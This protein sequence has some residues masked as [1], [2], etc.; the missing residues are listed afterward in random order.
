[1]ISDTTTTGGVFRNRGGIDLTNNK[2]INVSR[3]TLPQDAANKAYVDQTIATGGV[4]TGWSGFT[5]NNTVIRSRISTINL[6]NNGSGYTTE[7]AVIIVSDSGTGAVARSVL[8]AGSGP[9]GVGSIV[10]DD[11]GNGYINAPTVIIG[12]SIKDVL[13]SFGGQGYSSTPTLTFSEPQTLGGVRATGFAVM[14]GVGVNQRIERVVITNAGAGYTNSPTITQTHAG[15]NPTIA[16]NLVVNLQEGSGAIATAIITAIPRNINLNGNK[17]TG[18]TD[19]TDPTD[20]VTLK[21]FDESNFVGLINDVTITG[22]P[23]SGDFLVF[24]GEV[25]AGSQGAMVNAGLSI[26]SDLTVTRAANQITFKYKAGS[27]TNEF[28]S[29]SAGIAQTKLSL[30]RANTVGGSTTP[31]ASDFGVSCYLDTQFVSNLGFIQL[32]QSTS[33]LD[34]VTLNRIQQIDNFRLLGRYELGDGPTSTGQ[35]QE[36]SPQNVRDLI[37]VSPATVAALINDD[38]LGGLFPDGTPSGL[39][40]RLNGSASLGAL[41]KRGGTMQGKIRFSSALSADDINIT[42]ILEVDVNNKYDIGTN[43]ERFRHVYS[44][45]YTGATYVGTTFG[46]A[47]A[48]TSPG[49]G[50]AFNG[51]A[52]YANSL[53]TG[54]MSVALSAGTDIDMRA[55]VTQT[56]FNASQNVTVAV[57]TSTQAN[58]S[59]IAKRESGTLRATTFE[60]ALSGNAE[61][62]TNIRIGSTNFGGSTSALGSTVAVRDPSGNLSAT[63]FNGRAT[64]AN[65]ADLAEKYLADAKYSTGTVLEFGGEFEV[66]IAD[67]GTRRIAGVVSDKPAYLMNSQL[68]GEHVVAI[69]LQGRVPCLVR[70]KVRKGDMMISAG[71]GYA[72]ACEDPKLGSVIGKALE[73][74]DGEEGVIEVVVGRI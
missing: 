7:P 25:P 40:T 11:G 8:Q 27:I 26:N 58:N 73:D 22:T 45:N 35:I 6:T 74:F 64:S 47:E 70:G 33:R 65:Y 48:P 19:P 42:P 62:A 46:A 41:L 55:G 63:T 38:T 1:M 24:T 72:V 49:G 50:A 36:L 56:S 37:G 71:D 59:N 39:A 52:A 13:V 54:G 30:N 3:P 5:L 14:E 61:S 17:V 21:Y 68:I 67:A 43:N 69:A 29:P 44:Q 31:T 9:R 23:Q 15:D 34:G 60:G 18:S 66:T 53:G 10:I 28:I 57:I 2:I 4:R 16:A 32:R 51:T 12:G 20:L